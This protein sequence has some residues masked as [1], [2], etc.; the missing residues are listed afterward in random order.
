M[1]LKPKE[2][3]E[4]EKQAL[5]R[6]VRDGAPMREITAKLRRHAGSVRRM[7]LSMKLTIKRQGAP[8]PEA[9][10]EKEGAARGRS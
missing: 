9:A 3:T 8:P 2:W 4:A 5:I 7:A 1:K 10:S 6:L